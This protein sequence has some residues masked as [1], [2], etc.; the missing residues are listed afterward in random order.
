MVVWRFN[1]DGSLDITFAG[2]GIFVHNSAAGGNGDDSGNGIAVDS[3]DKILVGGSSMNS[4]GDADMA[5]W[6]VFP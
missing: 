2:Y 6:R 3:H 1:A 4:A 5:V